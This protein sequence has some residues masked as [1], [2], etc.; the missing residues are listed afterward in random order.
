MISN[1]LSLGAGP[2]PSN[3]IWCA[4]TLSEWLVSWLWGRSRQCAAA[5]VTL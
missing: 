4:L 5:L 2:F 1:G 3:G